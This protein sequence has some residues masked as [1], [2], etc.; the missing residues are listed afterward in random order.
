LL[1]RTHIN[2]RNRSKATET[3]TRKQQKKKRDP[4]RETRWM[5]D[6]CSGG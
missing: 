3:R 4:K 5:N 6:G 2:S 1:R